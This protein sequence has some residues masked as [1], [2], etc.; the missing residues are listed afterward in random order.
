MNHNL[1]NSLRKIPYL[2]RISA[3]AEKKKVDIWLVGGFL[4]DVYLKKNKQLVDFDFCVEKE[5]CS[6]ARQFAKE[7]GSK[8]IVLDE[9]SGSYRVI[10]KRKGGICTYDFSLM[11]GS[12][13]LEDLS[14]RDFSINTLSVNLKRKTHCVLD[15]F[16]AKKDLDRGVIR[17]IKEEVF[18]QDP[19]RVLRGLS[20]M[21]NYGFRIEGRT[22]KF[23]VKYKTFLSKVSRERINEELFKIFS[24]ENSYPA[25][26]KMSDLKIIDEIIPYV[27]LSRGVSQGGYHHLDVWDHSLET[28]R[29][30]E[31]IWQRRLK[32]DKDIFDYFREELAQGRSRIQI[33]KLACLLHDLGKPRA[34][35]HV[36]KKTIFYTHEKIGRDLSE[37]IAGGLRLSFRERE[38]LKKLVFWHLR[39]G[40]LADQIVP[41]SRAIYR[42]FRD[43]GEDGIAVIILSLS[44]WRATRGPLTNK[45]KRRKHEI[46]MLKLI[47][48]YL[49][50]K[51]K[52]PLSKIVDGD[53][54]MRKFK[55]SP[56]PLIGKILRKIEEEQSLGKIS[57][58]TEAYH[59]AKKIIKGSFVFR[60]KKEEI[61]RGGSVTLP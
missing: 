58:K 12:D 9:N 18:F 4:R 57:T 8:C 37:E 14:L 59:A 24:A 60:V 46:V 43:T 33:V 17:C 6:V 40:Y 20:F 45:K 29:K 34:K 16:D 15:A 3:I 56:S 51:K 42:F 7:T 22:E 5:V 52:T 53:D 31:E 26:K 41:S 1:L 27:G 21:A 13:L 49:A 55:L 23:M 50:E 19:L 38:V 47:D 11:R 30:F 28:L 10:L 39:P 61:C 32:K 35:K 54:L 25:V 44:D 48:F 36:N 2:S